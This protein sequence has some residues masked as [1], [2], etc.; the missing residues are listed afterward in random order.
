VRW[1][2]IRAAER[3][4][5]YRAEQRIG[6]LQRTAHGAVF[7]FEKSELQAKGAGVSFLM[8]AERPRYEVSGVNLHPFFAGLLPEGLR[9]GALVRR[10]K[11]SE[12]DLFSLALAAG[13]D[14]VGDV[15]LVVPGADPT[16]GG[17]SVDL[18]KLDQ[19]SFTDLFERCL[20]LPGDE[21]PAAEPSLPGIQDKISAAMVSFPVRGRKN[22][23]AHILKL[24]PRD[25]PTLVDNEAFF[26]EMARACGLEVPSVRL[27]HDRNDRKGLLVE[28]FDRLPDFEARTWKKIHLED[29]CQFLNRYP[30]DKYRLSCAA[31][32]EGINELASAPQVELL[33]FLRLVAFSY[34]IGNGDLHARN[35]S[36][37]V[38]PTAGRVELSP[39][40]DL[41]TTLPYG[42]RSMALKLE[43]RDDGLKR[44]YFV[45]FGNRYGLRPAAVRGMLDRLCSKAESWVLELD[46]I[47]LPGRR[48]ADLRR[49]MAQ[50]LEDLGKQ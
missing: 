28:R 14:S 49:V 47:G 19:V 25:I 1:E 20:E 46:H 10:I 21:G 9:L 48:T 45:S 41:L 6:F 50:R 12:D 15:A 2:D 24:S 4:E 29:A 43:G 44:A 18:T 31:I 22:T 36:L 42:D 17:P 3:A 11:T 7:E 27:V 5:V 38:E 26:M 32:A 39:A 23:G 35:V 37:R 8:P 16:A 13:P 40:Y 34:L 33:R 30:A